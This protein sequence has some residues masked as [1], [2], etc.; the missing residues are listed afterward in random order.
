VPSIAPLSKGGEFGMTMVG[1]MR[2]QSRIV[3]DFDEMSAR[4]NF[5][6]LHPLLQSQVPQIGLPKVLNYPS[7]IIK[8]PSAGVQPNI[9][10]VV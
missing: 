5:T 8:I 1:K 7:S 2:A 3:C 6:A 4:G 9:N 10:S